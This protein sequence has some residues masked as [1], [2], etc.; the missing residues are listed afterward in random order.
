MAT[1]HVIRHPNLTIMVDNSRTTTISKYCLCTMFAFQLGSLHI[2]KD[3]L[4]DSNK[5]VS[6]SLYQ[7]PITSSHERQWVVG[8]SHY[9]V[10]GSLIHS[11]QETMLM[12]RTTNFVVKIVKEENNITH[13]LLECSDALTSFVFIECTIW[14]FFKWQFDNPYFV[15]EITKIDSLISY[16]IVTTT[17]RPSGQY[18]VCYLLLL[19]HGVAW[20]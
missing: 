5:F 18:L 11:L 19:C 3:V 9:R 14:F 2:S 13:T 15:D 8:S 6:N 12:L 1:F 16:P 17:F 7:I 20:T 4:Y 10:V